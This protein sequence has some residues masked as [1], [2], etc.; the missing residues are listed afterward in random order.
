MS[1][2]QS[3]SSSLFIPASENG[4][5]CLL[6]RERSGRGWA[7]LQGTP[8]ALLV[9]VLELIIA[10][11]SHLGL[12]ALAVGVAGVFLSTGNELAR[13][14]GQIVAAL[15][16]LQLFVRAIC[17]PSQAHLCQ[18][19]VPS[20]AALALFCEELLAVAVG[21]RL[22]W[23]RTAG[24]ARLFR[25]V[26][27]APLAEEIYFRVVVL[28]LCANRLK[29]GSLA[30]PSL[31]SAALFAVAHGFQG[32]LTAV[33]TRFIA[34]LAL[35]FRFERSSGNLIEVIVL[36]SL[37]NGAALAGLAS[38]G[39]SPPT[40]GGSI[41]SLRTFWAPLALFGG[42]A[43]VDAVGLGL[44]PVPPRWQFGRTTKQNGT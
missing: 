39:E 33:L 3:K 18:L 8:A 6:L 7:K 38:G 11:L 14:A 44:L 22:A 19:R 4:L 40:S 35:A 30:S 28:H 21:E 17:A 29:R 27:V 20:F 2:E 31:A 37:H 25:L 41:A 23:W 43:L 12:E 42:M 36:H 1:V 16:L 34:G 26:V 5:A 15:F 10:H 9:L 13:A 32:G 24:F